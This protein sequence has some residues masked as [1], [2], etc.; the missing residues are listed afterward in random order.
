MRRLLV[1][2]VVAGSLV[3]CADPAAQRRA[4]E[5]LAGHEHG[6]T[7]VSALPSEPLTVEELGTALGCTPKPDVKAAD[8]HQATCATDDG[9]LLLLDFATARGQREWLD[10]ALAYG[11]TYL[12]GDRWVLGAPDPA[13]LLPLREKFGGGIEGGV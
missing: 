2:A 3:A 9:A 11:N 13:A 12:V 7:S 10:Q 5:L 8:Y 1:L 6:R 4:E